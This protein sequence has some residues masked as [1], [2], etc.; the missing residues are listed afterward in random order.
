[1]RQCVEHSVRAVRVDDELIGLARDENGRR[2]RAIE[3][4]KCD[5]G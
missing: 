5:Y 2:E 1:M 3:R 4:A